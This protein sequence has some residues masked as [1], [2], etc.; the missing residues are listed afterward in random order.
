MKQ[1]AHS[2]FPFFL[3]ISFNAVLWEQAGQKRFLWQIRPFPCFLQKQWG[4]HVSFPPS[5]LSSP[6]VFPSYLSC[7]DLDLLWIHRKLFFIDLPQTKS[8]AAYLSMYLNYMWNMFCAN[9][10]YKFT[11]DVSSVIVVYLCFWT[12]SIFFSSFISDKIFGSEGERYQVYLATNEII[13][14]RILFKCVLLYMF[15]KV[16]VLNS[17]AFCRLQLSPSK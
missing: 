8:H 11:T 5:T 6:S 12:R 15:A 7:F 10:L 14:L 4:Q 9:N 16:A 2:F 17:S 13:S 3:G 1:F